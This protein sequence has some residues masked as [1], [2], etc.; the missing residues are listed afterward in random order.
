MVTHLTTVVVLYHLPEDGWIAGQNTL[1]NVL[2]IK[3]HH[4]ITVH[5]LFVDTFYKYN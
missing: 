4:K 3:I 1:E 5:F 2:Y